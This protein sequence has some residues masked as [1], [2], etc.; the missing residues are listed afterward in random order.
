MPSIEMRLRWGLR[1]L[2]ALEQQIPQ[3]QQQVRNLRATLN[4]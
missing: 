1:V 3:R 2:D 4:R